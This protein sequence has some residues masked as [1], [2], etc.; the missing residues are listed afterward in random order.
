MLVLKLNNFGVRKLMKTLYEE[1]ERS[2]E[3][4]NFSKGYLIKKIIG[5]LN[6]FEIIREIYLN[7]DFN[8]KEKLML[9]YMFN[10]LVVSYVCD[11]KIK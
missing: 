8:E 11:Y 9:V 1:L 7:K 10:M 2:N 5:E 3:L 4:I 6:A